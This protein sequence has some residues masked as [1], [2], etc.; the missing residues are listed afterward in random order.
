MTKQAEELVKFIQERCLWQFASRAHDREENIN[1]VLSM[2]EEILS[3]RPPRLE[4]PMDR[5]HFANANQLVP[6]VTQ[7]FPWLKELPKDELSRTVSEAVERIREVTITR[8]QNG[9][10]HLQAY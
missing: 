2:M 8:S 9:E 6:E 4:T 5:C 1:G 10:L 7:A 3:G